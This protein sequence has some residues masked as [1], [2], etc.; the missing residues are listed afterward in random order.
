MKAATTPCTELSFDVGS[1]HVRRQLTYRSCGRPRHLD[2]EPRR[3]RIPGYVAHRRPACGCG[4]RSQRV[5]GRERQSFA[6]HFRRVE[7]KSPTRSR[8]R[9][10]ISPCSGSRN[11]KIAG[12]TSSRTSRP[13]VWFVGSASSTPWHLASTPHHPHCPSR[14]LVN[15]ARVR[16]V[17]AER[18]RAWVPTVGPGH[19][20]SSFSAVDEE[21]ESMLRLSDALY[22]EEVVPVNPVSKGGL[23]RSQIEVLAARTSFLNDCFY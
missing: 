5:A 7:R 21:R 18:T 9:L 22:L 8:K 19:A 6:K 3:H 12:S 11:W 10:P 20:L 15:R 13:Q 16:V 17:G 4:N 2:V 14:E 1:L 23:I